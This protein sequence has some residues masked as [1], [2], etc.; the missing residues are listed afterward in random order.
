MSHNGKPGGGLRPAFSPLGIW[1]FSIG[2]SI[3]WG[4]FIV[5]CNTY[6]LKS[7][8][9]G[10]VFGMLLG[11]G[12]IL[13]ITWNLQDMI[14]QAPSAG[15][16]YSFESRNGE[17]DLGFLA[18]WF[19]LLTYLAILWANMTS[20]P[21]FAR[22]F[23]GDIFRFGFRYE[24]F[25]YEVWFGE[26]LLSLCALGLV[27][28]LCVSFTRALN[29]IMIVSALLFAA[30]FTVC[31][32]FA[33]IRHESGFSYEP[34]YMEGSSSFGQIVRIAV[35]SPWAFIGF[36]NIAHFSEEYTFPVK[37]IRRILIWSVTVTTLLYLFVSLLSISAYPPEYDSWA[38][39]LGDMGNLKGIMAV[40]AFYAAQHYLGQTGVI[41]L[42][43]A[44][45]GVILTSLIANMMAVSRLLYAAARE[46]TASRVLKK[47]N[48]KGIPNRA[49]W[50][51]AAVCLFVPFLGR[52]AI[53]WIVD[54][55]T[56][57]ATIIYLLIS[58]GVY[59]LARKENRRPE[60]FTGMAGMV[61]MVIFTLLLLIPGLLP[62]HAMETESYILFIVWSVIG[63]FVF[64]QLIRR[65]RYREYGQRVIVWVILLVLVLF[66][67]MMC[68]SRATEKAADEAVQRI[69]TYHDTHPADDSDEQVNA[70]RTAFLKGEA[71]RIS[72]TNI[73]YTAVSLGLFVLFISIM[74][75]NYRDTRRLGQQLSE[76]E[77]KAEEER[78]QEKYRQAK[79]RIEEHRIAYAR[80][81]AL[82]GD[83]L[84]VHVVDPETDFFREYRSAPGFDRIGMPKEG[85]DFFT[86]LREK[87]GKQIHPEDL[88]R[89]LHT[90][91]RE[92]VLRETE[93]NGL[94][95]LTCR[96]NI[97]EKP[98]FVQIKAA[99]VEEKA[100]RRLIIGI[101]DINDQVRQEEEYR[102]RLS[103]A[104]AKAQVDALTG[105]KN[106]HAYLEAEEKL[107]LLIAENEAPAFAVSLLDVNDLK[108]VNDNA[109]H[110][111]GDRYL[112]DACAIICK[113]YKHSPVFRIGGDEF[114][115]ISQGSDYEQIDQLTAHIAEQNEKA[116]REGGIVIA[117]GMARFDGD[118]CVAS[119]FERAD[120]QMYL[121][122]TGLKQRRE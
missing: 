61:L 44:L 22:F 101:N 13:I 41:V 73:L 35:I 78:Q 90:F 98:G 116:R 12:V 69:H 43:A 122:K 83:Y 89:F 105:V 36:E 104:Q 68:V 58:H 55:T 91:T 97:D 100:G 87:C 77:R 45:F 50:A 107:D 18:F 92:N 62:F 7:G 33:V 82:S 38:A 3:G 40:P 120:Q 81:N 49:V 8:L 111:A 1:A 71:A 24:I 48:R 112:R 80:I 30:A 54:V 94:F 16:I 115:V 26:A 15:G 28:L 93:Q 108:K 95:I 6:L 79:A 57:G 74:L 27:A 102:L 21:L 118:S 72:S 56:L 2:T 76:T 64:R 63:L 84:S 114:A 119:V 46:G 70:E 19:I 47:V 96:M 42:M 17:K 85:N 11:M 25:G 113:N 10:T 14:R 34:L 53:G 99:M 110:Q 66:A 4:S 59:R 52:T 31:A 103:Q 65:D 23:L 109:G 75:N 60:R 117:C 106:K 67:S 88:D 39:Y 121:N 37:R 20:V 32:V 5:T 86:A 9:L 51:V 29:R